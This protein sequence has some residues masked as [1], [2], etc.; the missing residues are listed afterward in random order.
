MMMKGTTW[1]ETVALNEG[2]KRSR[3]LLLKKLPMSKVHALTSSVLLS[4]SYQFIHCY[5]IITK[6]K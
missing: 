6:H 1:V 4:F 2:K 5:V 3:R